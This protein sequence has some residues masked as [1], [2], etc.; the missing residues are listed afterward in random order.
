MIDVNTCNNILLI[1]DSVVI[2]ALTYMLC[3]SNRL[4]KKA[5]FVIKFLDEHR[6][7]EISVSPPPLGEEI[8]VILQDDTTPRTVT[9]VGSQT[10]FIDDCFQRIILW[11]RH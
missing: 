7:A 11:R 6:W 5:L 9:Y 10:V 4:M 1:V 2:A 8:D 3:S